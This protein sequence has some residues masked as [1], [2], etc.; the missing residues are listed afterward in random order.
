MSRYG[1]LGRT[2]GHSFSPQIHAQ[3][4]GCTDYA[5]LPMEEPEARA[6]LAARAFSGVNVTIPYKRLALELCD[7]VDATAARIGA[8][9]TVVNRQGVLKGYNTDYAGMQACLARAGIGLAGKKVL[10]LGS[11]GTSKTAC[12]VARDAGA[13]QVVVISRTGENNYDNLEKHRDA[14]ILL[15]T[16]PVGMFPKLSALPVE[17]SRF[18]ALCGVMD[19]VYNP[20]A[21]VLVQKARELKVPA[22]GGLAML[23]EQGRAAAQLFGE[24]SISSQ[25]ADAC[26]AQL[27][28]SQSNVVLIGMPGCGK[29]T[30][31]RQLARQLG[32][33]FVDLDAEIEQEAGCAIPELF[34]RQGE[35]AFRQ[36]ETRQVQKWGA[37]HGLVLA[38]GGGTPLREENR[39]ALRANGRIYWLNCEVQRLSGVGR[40]L[41]ATPEAILKLYDQRKEIYRA[42]ADVRLSADTSPEQEA[43]TIEEDFNA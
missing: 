14:E 12:A 32:R 2:L 41:S 4:W 27:W 9:N 19:A 29:T 38:C 28:R 17:P 42:L 21:T 8:V 18:P 43:R 1:L 11:G 40:P 33:P 35:E 22:V 25:A 15:N 34:A 30:V 31:G 6:F 24:K 26:L 10:V 20:L 3:L 37:E 23:V 36:M 16:T 5:L 13:R 7:E 39:Q